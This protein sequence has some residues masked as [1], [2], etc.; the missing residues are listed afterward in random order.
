MILLEAKSVTKHFGGVT[1]LQQANF[2]LMPGEVHILLGSNGCGKSTLCKVI[3][4]V[5]RPDSG[6]VYFQGNAPPEITPKTSKNAGVGVVY[7]ELSLI[8]NLTVAQN[9]MLGIEPKKRSIIDKEKQLKL[10]VEMFDIFKELFPE[11]FSLNTPLHLLTPDLRQLT[12]IMKVLIRKP[13]ILILDEPTASLSIGQVNLFFEIINN[14]KGEGT[15]IIFISHKM[16]E[17]FRIGDRITVMRGGETLSTK[18]VSQTHKDEIISLMVGNNLTKNNFNITP[19]NDS[20]SKSMSVTM[21]S[22]YRL[23]DISFS[24]NKGEVLGL[25]GLQGQGQRELLLTLFGVEP[26]TKGSVY[27]QDKEVVISHPKQAMQ[28]SLAYITGDR[29]TSG[30]FLM[31]SILDNLMMAYANLHTSLF[32]RKKRSKALSKEVIQRL[33][34]TYDTLDNPVS[35]LSGGNQQKVIIGRWLLNNPDILLMDDPTK[36]VDVQTKQELYQL[37]HTMC[38]DGCSVIWNSS[39]D[40]ELLQNAHRVLVLRDGHIAETLSGNSL[41]EEML[42]KATLHVE[43]DT[44]RHEREELDT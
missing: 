35:S 27:L 8:P 12:E 28:N 11:N 42:Y 39:D 3:S 43:T 20:D 21:L 36:G 31:R 34:L 38:K 6:K 16:E 32:V 9:I 14:L 37:I 5:V 15:G 29:K 13:K 25:G 1:A 24:L 18:Q 30:V 4:G 41:T 2:D 17:I 7:Q 40:Q 22:G 19:Y 23:K 44:R 33:R 10:L 26:Y